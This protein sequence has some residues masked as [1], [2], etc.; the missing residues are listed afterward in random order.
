MSQ[1]LT[2][3][4]LELRG[5]KT[6]SKEWANNGEPA[7][8]LH[9]GLSATEDWEEGALPAVEDKFHVFA[10]DR[11]AHG[12]T[13]IREGFYHF[14][15]QCDEAIAYIEDVIGAPTHL[16]GWSDG[17][18][19]SLLVALKRPD[20]VKSIVAIGTNYHWDAGMPFNDEP[21]VVNVSE[22]DAAEFAD[23]SPDPAHI[24]AEIIQRAFEVWR[25]EPNLT[26]ADL[27]KIKCPVLVLTG[28][29]E[30]F[31]N[32]HTVELYEALPNGRLAIIPGASHYVVKEKNEL[33]VATIKDFYQHPEFPIT[34]APRLRG[35]EI[36]SEA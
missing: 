23:R 14:D 27:A 24:Q 18:I 21:I 1:L 17:G 5:H 4:Y 12:R 28:D 3:G 6:W 19:I 32:H 2:A 13:G 33:A 25:T 8:L 34:K 10:Y 11:T 31:S 26:S 30:P 36:T 35:R 16:L 20:L 7:L 15:F 22:E 29:D 9:G